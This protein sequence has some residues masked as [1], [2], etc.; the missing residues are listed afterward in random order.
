MKVRDKA[1]PAR[2]APRLELVG[3]QDSEIQFSPYRVFT[4]E[5]WA[6]LRADTPMTLEPQE[7]EVL[8]GLL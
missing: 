5:Q 4:R 3:A 1:A 2:E 8:S 7:L 6:K